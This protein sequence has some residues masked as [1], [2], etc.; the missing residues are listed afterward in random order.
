MNKNSYYATVYQR[1][2]F[3]KDFLY[4]LFL[5]LSSWPRL[6]LEVFIRRNMGERYF[7]LFGVVVIT[8]LLIGF[9]FYKAGPY[10]DKWPVFKENF[11]WYL[12]TVAFVYFGYR[13]LREVQTLPSVFDFER[14]SLSS[15]I[16]FPIVYEITKNPRKITT[17][18]EPGACLLIGLL[19]WW[20]DQ[21]IGV[22]ITACSVIYSLSYMAAFSQGDDFL[23]DHIDDYICRSDLAKT[24]VEGLTSAETRGAEFFGHRPEN[25][26]ARRKAAEAFEAEDIAF[27]VVP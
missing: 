6:I 4:N 27:D 14:F 15:G 10:S 3:I 23:M 25:P 19:L 26:E 13:R 7:S 20:M 5:G 9:P 21:Q 1:R 12:F 22:L 17:L 11:T 18:I 24:F 2:N 16:S 8:L